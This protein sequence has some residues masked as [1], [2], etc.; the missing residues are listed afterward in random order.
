MF[1]DGTGPGAWE[2]A[3]SNLWSIQKQTREEMGFEKQF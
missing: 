3:S 2:K 1:Y